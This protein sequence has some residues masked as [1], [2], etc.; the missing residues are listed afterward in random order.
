[1]KRLALMAGLVISGSIL[2]AAETTTTLQVSATV[3]EAVTIT[4]HNLDFGTGSYTQ[5]TT[6]TTTIEVTVANGLNYLIG[7]GSSNGQPDSRCFNTGGSCLLEYELYQDDAYTQLWGDSCTSAGTHSGTCVNGTGTGSA[8]T[9]TVYGKLFGIPSLVP[10][11]TY[12]DTLTVT[13]VY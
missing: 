4:A 13:V 5:E 1:M 11:G 3:P 9:Y 2:L 10:A 6:A 7:I 12:T 8:Q